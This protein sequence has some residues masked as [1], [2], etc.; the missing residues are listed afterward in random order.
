MNRRRI[1]PLIAALL[2]L[3]AGAAWASDGAA[4]GLEPAGSPVVV[5]VPAPSGAASVA[6]ETP[7]GHAGDPVP[8]A[9]PAADAAPATAPALAPSEVTGDPRP[10][11]PAAA[12]PAEGAA[13]DFTSSPAP[14]QAATAMPVPADPPRPSLLPLARPLWSELTDGQRSVLQPFAGNWN[15]LPQSEKKAWLDVARRFPRMKPEAQA[16]VA[17]RIAEWAALGAEERRIARANYQLAQRIARDQ[18]A[19]DWESY[20][21]MTPEQRSVLGTVGNPASNTAARH[22]TG[23]TGLARVAAQP[24]PRRGPILPM[25][26]GHGSSVPARGVSPTSGPAPTTVR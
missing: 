16:R 19:A 24:L 22:V 8:P 17:R 11:A 12:A 3:G 14:A 13:P 15:A 21:S 20:Q 7:T 10:T 1:P 26:V 5:A 18:V 2:S 6:P 9:S 25:A 4:G 23:R